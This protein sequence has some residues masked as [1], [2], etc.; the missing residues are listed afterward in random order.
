MIYIPASKYIQVLKARQQI[1]FVNW[2]KEH[3]FA[4]KIEILFLI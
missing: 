4:G 1:P 3:L 2:K